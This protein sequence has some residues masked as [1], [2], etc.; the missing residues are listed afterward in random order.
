MQPSEI[1]WMLCISK[2]YPD[3]KELLLNGK[4]SLNP[5]K[6]KKGFKFLSSVEVWQTNS[7]FFHWSGPPMYTSKFLSSIKDMPSI[8]FLIQH[9]TSMHID[10]ISILSQVHCSPGN[11][12]SPIHSCVIRKHKKDSQFFSLVGNDLNSKTRFIYLCILSTG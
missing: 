11:G 8:F 7:S 3:Q 12:I 10:Q 2:Q 1:T 4:F 6:K 5:Q 9:L